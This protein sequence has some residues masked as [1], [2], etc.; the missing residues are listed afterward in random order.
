M[1][2]VSIKYDLKYQFKKA[3]YYKMTPCRKVVNTRTGRFL[4]CVLN[5]GSIGWWI[6]KDFIAKSKVNESVELIP[7]ETNNILRFL[8]SKS[9]CK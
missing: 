7:I 2:T 5:G 6:G 1:H 3:T 9:K 4:K 8:N